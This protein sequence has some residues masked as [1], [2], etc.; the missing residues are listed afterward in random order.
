MV[1]F[2]FKRESILDEERTSMI[3]KRYYVIFRF[4]RESILDEERKRESILD[5]ERKRESVLDEECN[6]IDKM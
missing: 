4:K 3:S 2:R 1:K 6:V 5:E